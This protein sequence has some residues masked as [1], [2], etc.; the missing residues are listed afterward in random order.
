MEAAFNVYQQPSST[1]TSG[2]FDPP[3]WTTRL[4]R[5][6]N[7]VDARRDADFQLNT[8]AFPVRSVTLTGYT[9]NGEVHI[10]YPDGTSIIT[11][12]TAEVL[13]IQTNTLGAARAIG[14]PALAIFEMWYGPN[15]GFAIGPY[16][17]DVETGLLAPADELALQIIADELKLGTASPAEAVARIRLFYFN[18]FSYT[19]DLTAPPTSA[20]N[21]TPLSDFLLERRTGHCEF[22]ATA[23]TLLLRKAGVP[24]RYAVG[25]SVQEKRAEHQ[26]VVR[27]RHAHAWTLAWLGNRW[28]EVD[29]TPAGWFEAEWSRAS[30]WES[31]LDWWSDA[32]LAFQLWRQGDGEFRLYVL[33]AGV[34]ALSYLAWRQVAGR[35]WRKARSGDEAGTGFQPAGLDSEFFEIERALIKSRPREA[36]ESMRAWLRRQN[37]PEA[38]LGR[39]L[40]DLLVLHYRLRFD[41]AGLSSDERTRLRHDARAWL[42]RFKGVG[43]QY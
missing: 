19:L 39:R 32:W 30:L 4:R 28:V 34:L 25:Y 13:V 15:G 6:E 5:F 23:T 40:Q 9:R 18:H 41:P 22:F 11:D 14:G 37:F 2:G 20:T 38:E 3:S 42:K 1:N 27:E 31:Q 21:N 26:F 33:I 17:D 43:S 16:E 12:K 36:A 24:A 35:S 29:F 8:N 10:P 7:S